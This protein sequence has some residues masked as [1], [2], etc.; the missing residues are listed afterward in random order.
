[1]VTT[2]R[3]LTTK[4]M[5][6]VDAY[7][8]SGVGVTA[9]QTAGYDTKNAYAM[10]SQL[11]K[12]T[13]VNAE[14]ARRRSSQVK[15]TEVTSDMLISKAWSVINADDTPASA[16]LQG[17]QMLGKWLGHYVERKNISVSTTHVLTKLEGLSIEQLDA[18]AST[19][20][21]LAIEG[22]TEDIGPL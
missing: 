4:Q 13:R 22:Q 16:K 21:A 19:G 7:M 20:D 1:M 6:F 12:N 2:N 10:A 8:L 14:I 9:I 5:A 17:I 11:L 15:R 3:P 18:L